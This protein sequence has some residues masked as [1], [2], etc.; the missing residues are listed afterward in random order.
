MDFASKTNIHCLQFVSNDKIRQS[1]NPF[2]QLR[3]ARLNWQ[4]QFLVRHGKMSANIA[5]T[6]QC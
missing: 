4:A 6:D 3:R 2:S 5:R 1:I